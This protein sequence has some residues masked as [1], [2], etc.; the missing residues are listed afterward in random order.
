MIKIKDPH[1]NIKPK[2]TIL[3]IH[4]NVLFN[5]K[6]EGKNL[7]RLYLSSLQKSYVKNVDNPRI[8]K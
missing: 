7:D 4:L 5:E 6:T 8:T 2:T 1:E 3:S